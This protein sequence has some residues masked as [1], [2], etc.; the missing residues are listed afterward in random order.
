L[1]T[2]VAY[3][4]NTEIIQFI[5]WIGL[6]ETYLQVLTLDYIGLYGPLGN[7]QDKCWITARTD[8]INVGAILDSCV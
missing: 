8:I 2:F 3:S 6:D 7:E 5:D 4:G 1:V